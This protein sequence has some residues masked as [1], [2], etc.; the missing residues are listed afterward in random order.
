MPERRAGHV[1]ELRPVGLAPVVLAPSHLARVGVQVALMRWCW[2]IS[3][4]RSREKND[5][6][7]LV[8]TPSSWN[9]MLWL[10]RRA[11]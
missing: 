1:H 2:P 6:A 8:S 9:A 4:R 5:S 10:I 7:W 3:A 11:S